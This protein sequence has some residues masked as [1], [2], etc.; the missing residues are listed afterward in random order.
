MKSTKSKTIKIEA[1]RDVFG[2]H[3]VLSQKHNIDLKQVKTYPLS[4]IPWA[5]ATSDGQFLKTN[6]S[7]LMHKLE[8]YPIQESYDFINS[9]TCVIDGNALFQTLTSL[10]ETFGE[11]AITVLRCLPKSKE[12]H[13][14]T[15]RYIKDSIKATERERRGQSE[16]NAQIIHG[17][18]TR[19]PKNWKAFLIMTLTR[20]I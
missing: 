5:L 16:F 11:F 20:I 15:D 18:S 19:M 14:V 17:P 13:F 1:Q 12:E 3:L 6:K 2:Q 9:S 7:S 10:P 4:L 8:K